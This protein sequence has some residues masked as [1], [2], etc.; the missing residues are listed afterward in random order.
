M[1]ERKRRTIRG[2][3]VGQHGERPTHLAEGRTTRSPTQPDFMCPGLRNEQEQG[4]RQVLRQP[5][6]QNP[7]GFQAFWPLNLEISSQKVQL[8]MPGAGP[9]PPRGVLRAQPA[10]LSMWQTT[11]GQRSVCSVAFAQC[12]RFPALQIAKQSDPCRR[13]PKSDSNLNFDKILILIFIYSFLFRINGEIMISI[14]SKN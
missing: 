9:R 1:A 11:R 8:S 6:A 2:G 10:V 7:H 14:V 3:V 13:C 5:R 4:P 12:S